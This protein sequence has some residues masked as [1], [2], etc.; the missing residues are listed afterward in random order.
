MKIDYSALGFTLAGAM[1]AANIFMLC[2]EYAMDIF[3]MGLI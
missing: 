1:I 3:F 2:I